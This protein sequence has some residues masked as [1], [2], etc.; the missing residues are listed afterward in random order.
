MA[1]S[2]GVGHSDHQA[3]AVLGAFLAGDQAALL[4][5]GEVVRQAAAVPADLD[6]ELT[7]PQ[8]AARCLRER[9]EHLV[10]RP[11][12]PVARELLFQERVEVLVEVEV[13][14]PHVLLAVVE[15]SRLRHRR[16]VPPC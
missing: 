5:A 12:Q 14:L 13:G 2:A 3:A 6:A 10:V 9:V 7:G 4:H 15:P 16:T 1:R 8:Q 11:R